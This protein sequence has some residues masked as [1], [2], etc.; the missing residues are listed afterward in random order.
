ME[1]KL[2]H[3]PDNHEI[4]KAKDDGIFIWAIFGYFVGVIFVFI[5]ELIHYRL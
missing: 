1:D 2:D 4:Q 5:M 3:V